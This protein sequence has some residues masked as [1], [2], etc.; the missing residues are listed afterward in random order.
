MMREQRLHIP[1]ETIGAFCHRWRIVELS[2]FGS[3]ARGEVGPD[4]D[5]D[6]LVTFAPDA[7]WSLLDLGRAQVEL[8][9]I[10]GRPIDMIERSALMS[11]H[12][13]WLRRAILE[14][15][16]VLYEAA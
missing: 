13:P 1:A 10:V 7:D 3:A 5:L 15:A 16:R 14:E 6:I 9:A 8:E 11:H 2:L 4:S 12:N